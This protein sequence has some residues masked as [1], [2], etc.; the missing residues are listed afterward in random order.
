M[1]FHPPAAATST[2]GRP[3]LLV[4]HALLY[5]CH[6]EP[7]SFGRFAFFSAAASQWPKASRGIAREGSNAVGNIS[8]PKAPPKLTLNARRSSLSSAGIGMTQLHPFLVGLR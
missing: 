5:A 4:A 7:S 6:S 2:T 3:F 8:P 1:S